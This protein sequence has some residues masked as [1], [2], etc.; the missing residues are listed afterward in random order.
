MISFTQEEIHASFMI[1]NRAILIHN[2]FVWGHVSEAE[3]GAQSGSEQAAEEETHQTGQTGGDDPGGEDPDGD[4]PGGD[5]PDDGKPP[6]KGGQAK[7]KKGKKD[8]RK[9]EDQEDEFLEARSQ[10]EELKQPPSHHLQRRQRL[11]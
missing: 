11:S 4:D 5:E 6:P 9:R 7:D 10:D 1:R 8:K 2:S 3:S